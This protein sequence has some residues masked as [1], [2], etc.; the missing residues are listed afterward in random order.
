VCIRVKVYVLDPQISIPRKQ[1]PGRRRESH[2][3][4]G[5]MS[6]LPCW[7]R[8]IFRVM[9]FRRAPCCFALEIPGCWV[10]RPLRSGKSA[11]ARLREFFLSKIAFKTQGYWQSFRKDPF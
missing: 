3:R 4:L 5:S 9:A 8:L 6:D 1:L 10:T 7:Q 2:T 11:D